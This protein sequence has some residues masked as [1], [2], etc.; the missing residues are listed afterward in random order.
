MNELRVICARIPHNELVSAE[1]K[2]LAGALPGSEGVADHCTTLEHV[3]QWA[4]RS[5]S[6]A[7][8]VKQYPLF[9]IGNLCPECGRRLRSMKWGAE[10]VTGAV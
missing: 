2:H 10:N 6:E 1:C 4:Y 3:A 5:L 7:K 9:K 8:P